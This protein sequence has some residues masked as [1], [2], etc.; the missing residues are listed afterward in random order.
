MSF[1]AVEASVPWGTCSTYQRLRPRGDLLP[2]GRGMR[3]T[4]SL[5]NSVEPIGPDPSRAPGGPMRRVRD[6]SPS[7][8]L[9][10]SAAEVVKKYTF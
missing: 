8:R 9:R 2:H 4:C 1:S 3:A 5:S 10:A 7:V 6:P